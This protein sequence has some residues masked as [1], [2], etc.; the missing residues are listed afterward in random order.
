LTQIGKQVYIEL[1][2]PEYTKKTESQA[3]YRAIAEN[4]RD[5]ILIMSKGKVSYTNDRIYDFLGYT[6]EELGDRNYLDFVVP[7]DREKILSVAPLLRDLQNKSIEREFRI[8]CKDGSVRYIHSRFSP[9]YN[10]DGDLL[11]VNTDITSIKQANERIEHA[12]QEWRTTFDAIRDMVWICD[13]DCVLTRVNKS[14]AAAAGRE[15]RECIGKK[16]ISLFQDA[17]NICG[18]C[19]HHRVFT[20]KEPGNAVIFTRRRYFEMQVSPIFAVNNEVLTAICA[21]HDI[22]EQ[23]AMEDALRSAAQK[24]RTT[25]DSLGEAICLT[26]TRGTILQCN[27]AFA[28][29]AGKPFSDIVG[30]HCRKIIFNDTTSPT[31]PVEDLR[32]NRQ[33]TTQTLQIGSRWFNMV[34]DV[35]TGENGE[36]SGTVLILSDI[37]ESKQ[38]KEQVEQLYTLE[39][40]L[41]KKLEIEIKQRT[42]FTR[43]LVHELKT[44][45]TSVVASSEL[46]SEELKEDPWLSL[47]RNIYSG[48]LNL[49]N[50]IDELLDIARGEIGMLKLNIQPVDVT[51]LFHEV[52][53]SVSPL[54]A[55]NKQ[56]LIADIDNI[57]VIMA[58]ENRLRQVLLNL[59]NNACK[60]TPAGGHI[61]LCA[62]LENGQLLAEVIDNGKGID[63]EDQKRI[64]QPYQRFETDKEHYSGL[65]LGLALS[66]MLVEL[67]GGKIWV[68]SAKGTG[69]TFAFSIPAS[70]NL[71][72]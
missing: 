51:R 15:P 3:L 69:S 39:S 1:M 68:T 24:W 61:S 8:V 66:R 57:P 47:A 63:K 37:T 9:L 40:E 43:A 62:H 12:A 58:D 65:G 21:I 34:G 55:A 6:R 72:P 36:F 20:T 10:A 4:T 33:R 71:L 44:P 17:E 48:A 60:Y 13:K 41:R 46:L 64:F 7:E 32:N 5:V 45:L 18:K 23:R 35:V 54:A 49:N 28:D 50:R 14:F 26:D 2:S 11:V 38:A 67:H 42:Y 31:C 59:L 22:T 30:H 19:P 70:M 56:T 53:T 52:F 27:Q 25:F 29:L 16:C